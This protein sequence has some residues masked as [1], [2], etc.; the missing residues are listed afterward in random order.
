MDAIKNPVAFPT[1][2][3]NFWSIYTLQLIIGI[4]KILLSL[5]DGK[6]HFAVDIIDP[7]NDT[8]IYVHAIDC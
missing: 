1:R 6:M 4:H 5:T 3:I 7:L 2:N 8:L